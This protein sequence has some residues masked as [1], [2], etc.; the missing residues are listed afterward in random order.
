MP[1]FTL[2]ISDEVDEFLEKE[3]D[4]NGEFS[5]KSEV[6]NHYFE[7]GRRVEKLERELEIKQ[8]RIEDLRRQMVEREKVE[9][10]VDVLAKR[11][12][13]QERAADAPFFVRW[14]R[15]W[16]SRNE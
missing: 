16:Q 14:M 2:T 3:S 10:K 12:E 7:Q 8:N 11:M 13:D 9:E 4:D 5:S 6:M 1:R 15:W